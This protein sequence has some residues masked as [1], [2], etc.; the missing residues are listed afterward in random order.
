M[1]FQSH[2]HKAN[3]EILSRETEQEISESVKVVTENRWGWR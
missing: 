3:W 1:S 2:N